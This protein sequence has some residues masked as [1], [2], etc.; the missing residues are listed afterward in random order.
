MGAKTTLRHAR[1][2]PDGVQTSGAIVLL[3]GALGVA[4]WVVMALFAAS[5]GSVAAESV[6]GQI[7]VESVEDPVSEPDVWIGTDE[8]GAVVFEGARE[9]LDAVWAEGRAAYQAELRQDWLYPPAAVAVLGLVL[10]GIG[11]RRSHLT[12]AR[13]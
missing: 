6:A 10:F 11:Y 4:A 13:A 9:E 8:S 7:A 3:L 1:A 2:R 12:G 5:Y